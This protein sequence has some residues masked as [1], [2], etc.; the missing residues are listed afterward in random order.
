[1]GD[2]IPMV[3]KFILYVVCLLLLVACGKDQCTVNP[4]KETTIALEPD[5]FVMVKFFGVFDVELVQDTFKRVFVTGPEKMVENI[6]YG[7][8]D[9][10]QTRLRVY[11]NNQCNWL[12]NYE[13]LKITVHSDTLRG[14]VTQGASKVTSRN[15]IKGNSFYA[16]A[17]TTINEYDITLDVNDFLYYNN[18]SVG[19]IYT[20]KG[21][22][23]KAGIYGYA[24]CQIRLSD[25]T[26]EYCEVEHHSVADFYFD[27]D[28][29]VRLSIFNSG[30][31]YYRGNI[32]LN[33]DTIAGEGK[34]IKWE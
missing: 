1:M 31:F 25:F 18:S 10:R 16:I 14:F 20:F 32:D 9:D 12:R 19:G 7:W 33:I 28:G 22:A 8:E 29:P 26:T 11:D 23:K 3:N 5:Y 27:V 34:A 17:V 4:G 30:N 21:Y 6:E 15:T 24:N 13:R 2:R